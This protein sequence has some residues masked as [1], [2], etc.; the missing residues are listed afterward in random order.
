MLAVTHLIVSLLLIQLFLLDR[1]DAFVALLFGVFI[2]VDHIL[3]LKDYVQANGFSA[4]LDFDSLSHAEG[5]WKS[6]MHSPTAVAIVAPLALASRLAIPLVFWG[7]HILMDYV[8]DSFLG[9]FSAAE[10]TFLVIVTLTLVVVRYRKYL[11]SFS[12]GT[13]RHYVRLELSRIGNL[14]GPADFSMPH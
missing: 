11:D 14:F 7:V 13:V 2:D 8:E 1:N 10:A 12:S 5:H 4:V 9:V 3:G 6:L